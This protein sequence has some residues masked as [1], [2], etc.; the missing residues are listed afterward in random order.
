MWGGGGVCVCVCVFKV[1]IGV[2]FVE[3]WH[4]LAFVPRSL[5]G[6][7]KATHYPVF[8]TNFLDSYSL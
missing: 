2:V 4:L 8:A 5:C 3:K 1:I 6:G 7:L